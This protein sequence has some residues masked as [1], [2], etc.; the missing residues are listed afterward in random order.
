MSCGLE[1][2]KK[3][4]LSLSRL[5]HKKGL[6]YLFKAFSSLDAKDTEL[7]VVGDG[8]LKEKLV[9]MASDLKIANK[10]KFIGSVPHKETYLWYNAAD[11]YC[12]PSLWEG[13]PNVIIESLAC[14]TPVVSTKVG[15]IPDLVPAN[16]YGFLVHAGD[17]V[18]LANALDSVEEE[19]GPCLYCLGTVL[20][21]HGAKWPI[22]SLKFLNRS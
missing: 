10:V 20:K 16:D 19:L 3:Y 21:T 6:E 17:A 18:S 13:C 5:S 9:I 1:D 12:L 15:G 11:V 14:G 7:V 22:G 4:I 2:N 8:P